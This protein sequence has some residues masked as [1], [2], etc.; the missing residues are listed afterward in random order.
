MHPRPRLR[1]TGRHC[2]PTLTV[3]GVLGPVVAHVT[4][5]KTE[6]LCQ[7]LCEETLAQL[8][9]LAAQIR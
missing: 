4:L 6:P 3:R 5:Y 9:E 8:A 7:R 1:R 2:Q